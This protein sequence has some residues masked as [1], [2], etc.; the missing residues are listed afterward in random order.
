MFFLAFRSVIQHG[1]VATTLDIY[2]KVLFLFADA[3]EFLHPQ[4]LVFSHSRINAMA[5]MHT[6]PFFLQ[7]LPA[8]GTN[9]VD[10]AAARD[11]NHRQLPLPTTSN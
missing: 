1:K 7:T 4:L 6:P 10:T 8:K 11:L 5:G 3:N 2:Y 9:T